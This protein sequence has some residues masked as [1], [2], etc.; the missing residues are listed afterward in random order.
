MKVVIQ[1]I[2]FQLVFEVDLTPFDGSDEAYEERSDLL[3]IELKKRGL[4]NDRDYYV[5]KV[6]QLPG[7]AE[8]WGLGT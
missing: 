4:D 2:D 1:D 6:T 7:D 3:A 8:Q 5:D